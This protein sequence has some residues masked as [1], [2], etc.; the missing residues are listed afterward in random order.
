MKYIFYTIGLLLFIFTAH[1][2]SKIS[3]PEGYR[4]WTHIKT[5]T[6]HAGHPLE[7]PFKGIH[8]IYANKAGLEGIRN[9]QYKDGATV[10][11]DLL[12]NNTANNAS[13][14]GKRILVG[15]MVKNK[16]KY[17]QTGGWGFE[18]WAGDSRSK[19]LTKDN[20]ASCFACHTSEKQSDYVF[21]QWRD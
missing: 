7:N 8:H 20:G 16:Q 5:L 12:E 13:S 4:Y 1:A 9:G 15:V 6:L 21:S 14:E 2:D 17:K 3:Y 10:V 18:A 11:F 19:R